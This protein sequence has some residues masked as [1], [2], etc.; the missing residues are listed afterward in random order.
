MAR[1][2]KLAWSAERGTFALDG[3]SLAD[4]LARLAQSFVHPSS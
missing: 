2:Y 3:E 4:L 1:S